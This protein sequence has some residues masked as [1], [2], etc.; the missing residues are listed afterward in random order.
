MAK[1]I[2]KP[3]QHRRRSK[4]IEGLK[5]R[6]S[7]EYEGSSEEEEGG[8][9]IGD[10]VL[11]EEEKGEDEDHKAKGNEDASPSHSFGHPPC[12]PSPTTL[13]STGING[14]IRGEESLEDRANQNSYPSCEEESIESKEKT[15]AE[16]AEEIRQREREDSTFVNVLLY[17]AG[18]DP[19]KK[20]FKQNPVEPVADENLTT[21]EFQALSKGPMTN[22][23]AEL[24]TGTRRSKRKA[25][26]AFGDNSYIPSHIQVLPQRRSANRKFTNPSGQKSYPDPLAEQTDQPVTTKRTRIEPLSGVLAEES[27][28]PEATTRHKDT[29]ANSEPRGSPS[30]TIRITS[31]EKGISSPI[32]PHPSLVFSTRL[33]APENPDTTYKFVYT[34]NAPSLSTFLK[35]VHKRHNLREE[36]RIG[37]FQVQIDNRRFVIILDEQEKHWDWSVILKLVRD[38]KGP[39]EV[40]LAIA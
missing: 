32:A 28:S 30:S 7:M 33:T 27:P 20:R 38:S 34:D 11:E 12:T 18:T 9:K 19:E 4:K 36:Q 25:A 22:L 17:A 5:D 24:T 1:R 6:G 15:K 8:N 37:S 10:D 13:G 2:R 39:V 40:T 16:K 31:A 23:H 3:S 14:P 21:S 29:P 26:K 35:K